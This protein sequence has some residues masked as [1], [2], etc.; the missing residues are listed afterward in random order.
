MSVYKLITIVTVVVILASASAISRESYSIL[1]DPLICEAMNLYRCDNIN[2]TYVNIT[3]YVSVAPNIRNWMLKNTST[4]IYINYTYPQNLNLSWINLTRLYV[5]DIYGYSPVTV[6]TDVIVQGN[7]SVWGNLSVAQNISGNYFIGKTFCGNMSGNVSDLCFVK[8]S[9]SNETYAGS[10]T[11]DP[12]V[13]ETGD[14]MTGNL[15][16][17]ADI[18]ANHFYGLFDC[19]NL[20]GNISDLCFVKDSDSNETYTGAGTQDLWINETG[21][22]FTGNIN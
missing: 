11:Q 1:E 4:E 16:V 8:D 20:T 21:D 9:D 3:Q 19:G 6:H 14:T 17:M 15:N 13:N 2:W 7:A 22:V 10:G 12:W 18:N 5:H